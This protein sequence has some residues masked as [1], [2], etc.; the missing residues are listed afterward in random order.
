MAWAALAQNQPARAAELM[1]EAANEE[2][3]LEKLPVTPGPVIPAREQLGQMLLA[4]QQ[5]DLAAREFQAAL[6]NSPGRRG[7][8]DGAAE[9]A[10]GLAPRIP[11]SEPAAAFQIQAETVAFFCAPSI[12][13]QTAAAAT[14]PRSPDVSP[15]YPDNETSV[16][17][18]M[19]MELSRASAAALGDSG[20]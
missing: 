14:Q 19:S 20:V 11:R 3:A 1:R 17:F 5:W 4:Q 15:R 9:A 2:D 12:A 18:S 13:S 16:L 6:V 7:A 10:K 8:I